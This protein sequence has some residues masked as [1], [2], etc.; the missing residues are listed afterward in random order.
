MLHTDQAQYGR[1]FGVCSPHCYK[2]EYLKAIEDNGLLDF[3]SHID[4]RVGAFLSVQCSDILEDIKLQHFKNGALMRSL[5]THAIDVSDVVEHPM[6]SGRFDELYFLSF[7]EEH[8][9][10]LLDATEN[11]VDC[12]SSFGHFHTVKTWF[13]N[14]VRFSAD[15]SDVIDTLIK[16]TQIFLGFSYS[17]KRLVPM[18]IQY[19]RHLPDNLTIAHQIC[20][21][22][23][24]SNISSTITERD[25]KQS[26]MVKLYVAMAIFL[27]KCQDLKARSYASNLAQYLS[28]FR[29]EILDRLEIVSCPQNFIHKLRLIYLVNPSLISEKMIFQLKNI[30]TYS[31]SQPLLLYKKTNDS[32]EF[33]SIHKPIS[34]LITKDLWHLLVKCNLYS[35]PENFP[36]LLDPKIYALLWPDSEKESQSNR[37]TQIASF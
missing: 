29:R 31:Y 26:D 5:L 8:A 34:S 4:M 25:F 35:M 27:E 30:V 17:L 12:R 37:R 7:S 11:T 20:G 18:L 10:L 13:D 16:S 1:I 15:A 21:L 32:C 19:A 23:I 6:M 28:K 36:I 22:A 24:L 33:S 9:E 2:K 14:Q 3:M